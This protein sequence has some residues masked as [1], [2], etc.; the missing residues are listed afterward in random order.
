M[1]ERV[2]KVI[3]E[4]INP[5]LA[6][7]GGACYLRD[8]TPEN[9]VKVKLEGACSGCPGAMMTLKGFVL[10]ELQKEIPEIKDIEAE[11]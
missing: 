11:M 5:M 3:N 1:R 7:H 8:V 6:T 4:K 9:V 10:R 2:N